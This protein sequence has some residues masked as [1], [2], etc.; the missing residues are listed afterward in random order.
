M[1]F[2]N[3]TN[4][5]DN[6]LRCLC[7]NV[8]VCE[9]ICNSLRYNLSY[10]SAKTSCCF[11]IF[12][13]YCCEG[14]AEKMVVLMFSKN[15]VYV[16]FQLNKVVGCQLHKVFRIT[17]RRKCG[18]CIRR[19]TVRLLRNAHVC[20]ERHVRLKFC[21]SQ[22]LGPDVARLAKSLR[23]FALRLIVKWRSRCAF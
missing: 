19:R 12:I 17:P 10:D 6:K 5:L 16:L 7:E 21:D 14:T 23:D 22:E 18:G 2:D 11:V 4:S 9:K 15:V 8:G 20:V 1:A 13:G 3:L